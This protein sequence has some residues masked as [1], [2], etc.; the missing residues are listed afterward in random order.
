MVQKSPWHAAKAMEKAA[1]MACEC[2]D[3][4]GVHDCTGRAAELYLEE[5]RQTSAADAAAKSARA[6]E[7]VDP[8]GASLLYRQ[9]LGWLEDAGKDTMAADTYRQA[10]SHLLRQQQW[11]D[12]VTTL[13][14]FAASCQASKARLS[15]CKAYLGAVVV[16]LYAGD[17]TQAWAAY[18]DALSVDEFASSD[19]A[20]A[21]DE[22]LAAYRAA[23]AEAI[24]AALKRHHAFTH[25]D[26]QVAKLA[27]KLPA[28]GTNVGQMAGQLGGGG[29]GFGGKAAEEEEE[30][31]T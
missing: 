12:A 11:A 25:L 27:K 24:A 29:G 16:W 22:L 19:E 30:D 7:E 9:A 14:R 26:N 23:D 18:Q 13:L 21:A 8:A 28:P 17:A 4:A 6:L 5:G 2:R 10:I 15:Q 31:L 3:W 1:E 20:F